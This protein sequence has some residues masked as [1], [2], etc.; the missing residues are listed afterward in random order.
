MNSTITPTWIGEFA[1][2][3]H[4][5]R[6]NTL[7]EAGVANTALVTDAFAILRPN[8]TV[9]PIIET[10]A[11]TSTTVT[12]GGVATPV[13]LG[14]VAFVQ[15]PAGSSLQRNFVQQ[16]FGLFSTQDRNR[17]EFQARFQNLYGR[18]TFK[19]GFEYN[20]NSYDIDTRSTG[21][22][23]TFGTQGL[24]LVGG[25]G[26]NSTNG[27]RVTNSYV[28]C[29]MRGAQVVCPSA[30]GTSRI[31][32]AIAAGQGPTEPSGLLSPAQSLRRRLSMLLCSF[33]RPRVFA[34][35]S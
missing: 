30:A 35:S 29:T 26:N 27:F 7:P 21:P 10:T 6:A 24:I 20:R 12:L 1:F 13:T 14:R 17:T 15:A 28:V 18:H 23:Q 4:L 25:A 3:L 11:T 31:S 2:G 19:Y 32:A 22:D 16:G 8:G 9:A 33:A 34:T 5:Q